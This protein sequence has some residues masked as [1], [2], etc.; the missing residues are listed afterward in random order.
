[1]AAGVLTVEAAYKENKEHILVLYLHIVLSGHW[2][3]WYIKTWL[4]IEVTP[5]GVVFSFLFSCLVR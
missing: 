1:M 2:A 4:L 5:K 3:A